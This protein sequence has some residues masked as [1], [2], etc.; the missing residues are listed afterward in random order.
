[1]NCVV[2]VGVGDIRCGIMDKARGVSTCSS[3]QLIARVGY[4]RQQVHGFGVGGTC[5]CKRYSAEV[6]AYGSHGFAVFTRL[7]SCFLRNLGR[8][9]GGEYIKRGASMQNR[10]G[11]ASGVWSLDNAVDSRV[12]WQVI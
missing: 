10:C 9:R 4:L 12:P 5:R 2:G 1:M 11:D 6:I 7:D 8:V 3:G